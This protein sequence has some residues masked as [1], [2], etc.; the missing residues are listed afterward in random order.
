MRSENERL[1][2]E[3]NL[4]IGFLGA[5]ENLSFGRYYT[6]FPVIHRINNLAIEYNKLRAD[7]AIVPRSRKDNIELITVRNALIKDR[8]ALMNF[9]ELIESLNLITPPDNQSLQDRIKAVLD[10]LPV[11]ALIKDRS[12]LIKFLKDI[13]SLRF[14][15]AGKNQSIQD[16]IEAIRDELPII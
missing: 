15:T 16:R 11:N 4:L 10:V 12:A 6:E 1:R 13:E 8:N 7:K 2:K 3:Y 14:I 9:L 5:L